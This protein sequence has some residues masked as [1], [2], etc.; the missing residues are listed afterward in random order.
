MP[1][2][3]LVRS[4]RGAGLTD[5][6][7]TQVLA[8]FALS[9]GQ[10]ASADLE[11]FLQSATSLQSFSSSPSSKRSRL[12]DGETETKDEAELEAEL[13]ALTIGGAATSEAEATKTKNLCFFKTGL[14]NTS[15]VTT[16]KQIQ[17]CTVRVF[18]YLK[19]VQY[20]LKNFFSNEVFQ[21][22]VRICL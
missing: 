16:P 2:E 15:T 7:L 17:K 3:A 8:G 14:Q 6:D 1:P 21:A 11:R 5:V 22:F 10:Q 20:V 18:L 9:S 4:L 19:L 12:A 13:R